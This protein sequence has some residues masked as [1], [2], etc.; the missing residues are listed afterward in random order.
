MAILENVVDGERII[1]FCR[2]SIGRD[3]HNRCVIRERDVSR[4]HAMIHWENGNW[5]LTDS[6]RNGTQLNKNMIYHSSEKLKQNDLIQFSVF[7]RSVW[8]LI[9]D[10]PPTSFLEAKDGIDSFIELKDGIIFLDSEDVRI[11]F[12]NAN[13]DWVLDDGSEEKILIDGE[14]CTIDKQEYVFVENE[15]LED[16]S[17]KFDFTEDACLKLYLSSDE[18]EVT[19]QIHIND[20]ILDLG[21]RTYNLL[22]L[23]LVRVKLA[24]RE[25]GVK[26]EL[27]GWAECVDVIE[28]LSK[29][30]LKEVDEFYLNNLIFRLRRRLMKLKPYGQLLMNIVERK[31]GKLRCG[32]SK[33][34]V[35]KGQVLI[36]NKVVTE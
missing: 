35:V 7:K 10:S 1:L 13:F 21:T 15:N 14:S 36:T 27:C 4:N 25:Y 16:T 24:D 3:Y 8:K 34:D 22:L 19:A 32:L 20:L 2:H 6:S 28:A 29:E 9:D 33:F 18:E 26:E 5:Y 17:K 30:V 12:R 11:L 23:H 31:K